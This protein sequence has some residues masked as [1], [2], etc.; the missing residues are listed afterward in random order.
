MTGKKAKG[1]AGPFRFEAKLVKKDVFFGVD[2]P[3]AVSKAIGRKGFVPILGEVNGAPL[4]TSL[5]PS[6]GGRHHVLL[7]REVREAAQVAPGDRVSMVLRVD[8]EPPVHDIADD[9][10]DALREE[11]VLGDFE[12]MA[13]GRRNQFIRWME[14]AAHEDTRAKRIARLV[15]MAH[16]EREK[17]VDREAKRPQGSR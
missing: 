1:R 8:L 11:G 7:N 16:A 17:R 12:S 2:L 10:A 6:G 5:S 14:D 9:L 15:E 4:Q 13:R 3:A